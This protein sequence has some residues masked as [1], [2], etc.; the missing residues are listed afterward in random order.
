MFFSFMHEGWKLRL[1]SR[2]DSAH[3]DFAVSELVMLN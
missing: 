2:E 3:D 1:K